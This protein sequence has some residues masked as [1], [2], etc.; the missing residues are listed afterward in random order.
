MRGEEVAM[1]A[2]VRRRPARALL[3]AALVAAVALVAGAPAAGA[4]DRAD[5][6]NLV[7]VTGRAEVHEGE[8]FH[9]VVIADGPVT[10]DG[11]VTDNVVAF[12]GDVTV[13]GT[14]EN[15]VV[16]LD[17]RVSVASGGHIA[18]DVTARHRPTVESGGRF[19]GSWERWNP[20]AWSMATTI[21]TRLALW[22]AVSISTLV[23]GLLLYLVAP[24]A[25][26]A[27]HEAARSR[28]GAAIGW[29]LLLAIG[30]PLA[31]L[32]VTATLIGLPLGLGV[33]FALGLI[34]GVGYVAAAWLLGRTVART[35]HPLLSFLAGWGILRLVALVPVLGGLCWFA[36]VV[37]GLGSIAVA[38]WR[39]RH[40]GDRI[41]VDG[42]PLGAPAPPPPPAAPPPPAPSAP[43]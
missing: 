39:A 38:I 10:V 24:R 3:A 33:L 11:T 25:P 7:V 19:D 22:L 6:D 35:A 37:I 17:G 40:P 27:V 30:L 23:L 34:Y 26:F 20:S 36:A 2:T 21:L 1:S 31:A 16:A 18:G 41:P 42:T 43:T 8:R 5:R 12:H 15:D 32:I 9:N 13:N 28:V 4:Q 29:G 14:V